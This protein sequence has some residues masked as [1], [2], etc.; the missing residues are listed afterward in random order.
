MVIKHVGLGHSNEPVKLYA[1]LSDSNSVT[2]D[3]VGD[4][5]SWHC[6]RKVRKSVKYSPSIYDTAWLKRPK[7]KQIVNSI[8]PIT[9]KGMIV[10]T[11]TTTADNFIC[12]KFIDYNTNLHT[13]LLLGYSSFPA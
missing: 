4:A 10:M 11:E 6:Q 8:V 2:T 5:T 1:W 3:L 9:A 12:R 7:T 13:S